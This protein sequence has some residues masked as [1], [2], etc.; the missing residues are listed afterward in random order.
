MVGLL[1]AAGVLLVVSGAGKLVR[2]RTAAEALVAAGLPRSLPAPLLA[3]VVGAGEVLAGAVIV[4]VGGRPAAAVTVVAYLAL[5]AFAVRLLVVAP[6]TACGCLSPAA[7][8][9]VSRWH[10]A[11]DLGLAAAGAVA[12]AAPTAPLTT[13]LARDLLAGLLVVAAAA[14]LAY[15]LTQLISA[16]PALGTARREGTS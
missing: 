9:P 3:R 4:L 15:L 11:V 5:A 8:T 12:L 1:L 16:L 14:L 2:P 6:S 7:R 13:L 10:V